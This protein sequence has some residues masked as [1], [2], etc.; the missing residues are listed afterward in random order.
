MEVGLPKLGLPMFAK[1]LVELA[2]RPRTYTVRAMF[3][4]LLFLLSAVLFAP[5]MQAAQITRLGLF[6][7]RANLLDVLYEVEWFGLCLFVPALVSGVPAAEKERNTLQLLLLTRL[8]PWAIL[9]A[10][11][12][13]RLDGIKQAFHESTALTICAIVLVLLAL[14]NR[15]LVGK[16]FGSTKPVERRDSFHRGY[17]GAAKNSV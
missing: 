15:Q 6:G 7:K 1:E 2:H 10:K 11:L 4:V 13:S 17:V 12:L 9:I 8:G 14:T 3:A 5:T 16:A